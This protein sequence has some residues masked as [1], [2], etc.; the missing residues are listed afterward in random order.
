VERSKDSLRRHKENL[1]SAME[2]G[3]QAYREAVTNPT[4]D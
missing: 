1:A 3:K 4:A 2:A